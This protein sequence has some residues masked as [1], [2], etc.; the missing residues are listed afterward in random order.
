MKGQSF[1]MK[2]EYFLFLNKVFSGF[3]AQSLDRKF[4]SDQVD[5]LILRGVYSK[6]TD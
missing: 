5:A 3:P 4:P 1:K 2:E 6:D